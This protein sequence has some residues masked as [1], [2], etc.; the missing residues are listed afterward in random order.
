MRLLTSL[1][2]P[3][4]TGNRKF[5]YP[6]YKPV[7]QIFIESN[8]FRLFVKTAENILFEDSAILC[9]VILHFIKK[10]SA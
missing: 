1:H 3:S 4:N 5:N 8:S 10:S 9:L 6:L 2:F 7:E